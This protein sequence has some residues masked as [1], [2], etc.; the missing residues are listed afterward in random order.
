MIRCMQLYSYYRSSSAFRV[1][2]ALNLKGLAY[3]QRPVNLDSAEQL[4]D[5][6]RSL[7]PQGRV[8]AL[9]LENGTVIAQSMAILEWLEEAHPEPA[10]LPTTA[11][12]RAHVRSLCQ[13]VACD[14]QPLNNMSVVGYLKHD[15]A[16]D[17]DA[18][19]RWYTHWMHR[20]FAALEQEV[21]DG[22]GHYCYG[23]APGLA[24]CLL[25]PQVFNA[26]RFGVDMAPFPT[27]RAIY[28]HC[29]TLD[30]FIAANP[31]NQPDT[32]PD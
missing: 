24:D 28:E 18:T 3:E 20:G 23:D 10:L 19:Q 30:A 4:S 14:M 9:V 16:A 7:N 27:V 12:A 13:Q 6:Y 11:A 5:S 2:I 15:L 26:Y 31:A 22:G 17:D 32:P 1:R 25:I 21:A 8:P 29:S